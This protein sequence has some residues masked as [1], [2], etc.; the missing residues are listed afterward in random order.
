MRVGRRPVLAV[1]L[2]GFILAS[3]TGP[4]G[5]GQSN[6]EGRHLPAACKAAGLVGNGATDESPAALFNL[7]VERASR[8]DFDGTIVILSCIIALNPDDDRALDARSYAFSRKNGYEN[9]I[10]DAARAIA[11]A[12]GLASPY[13]NRA[14]AYR[15]RHRFAEA[16]AD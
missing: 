14:Y 13:V 15:C 8:D 11:V 10:A 4:V 1:A 2:A 7:A 3:A 6:Q 16:L 12:P 9:A 5:A